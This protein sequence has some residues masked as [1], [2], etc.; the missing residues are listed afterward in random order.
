MAEGK[1]MSHDKGSSAGLDGVENMKAPT[2]HFRQV[3]LIDIGRILSPQTL[4]MLLPLAMLAGCATSRSGIPDVHGISYAPLNKKPEH[5][6][7]VITDQFRGSTWFMTRYYNMVNHINDVPR[8]KGGANA[9]A[10]AISPDDRYIAVDT[11]GEGHCSVEVFPLEPLL[12]YDTYNR[13]V[14]PVDPVA[15][16]HTYPGNAFLVGWKDEVTLE[17]RCDRP[18]HLST[19]D[20]R[21][22]SDPYEYPM[23]HFLWDISTESIRKK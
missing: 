21:G 16:V 3:M 20:D 19:P 6:I 15:Y 11:E 2:P 10:I 9:W 8:H 13:D 1:I 22:V 12:I 23:E 5:G 7:L 18:L 17:I 4:C 14:R